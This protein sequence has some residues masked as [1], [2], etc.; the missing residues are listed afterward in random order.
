MVEC[1]E[2]LHCDNLLLVTFDKEEY[3]NAFGT[4]GDSLLLFPLGHLLD[5]QLVPTLGI[6]IGIG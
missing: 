2:E 3:L 5:V 6:P 1:A 4:L